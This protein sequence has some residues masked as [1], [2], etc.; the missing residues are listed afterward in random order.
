MVGATFV[1][2]ILATGWAVIFFWP[3]PVA[4]FRRVYG[5]WDLLVYHVTI[6]APY[7]GGIDPRL[8]VYARSWHEHYT[9]T[10]RDRPYHGL[11]CEVAMFVCQVP[12]LSGFKLWGGHV[13]LQYLLQVEMCGCLLLK[14]CACHGFKLWCGHVCF[15]KYC[16][17]DE[18]VS[19]QS[20]APATGLSFW[21]IGP[22][23]ALRDLLN[24]PRSP[25]AMQRQCEMDWNCHI[26]F[27]T[28]EAMAATWYVLCFARETEH[29]EGRESACALKLRSHTGHVSSFWTAGF[30]ESNGY[31]GWWSSLAFFGF[32]SFS[33]DVY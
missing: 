6:A 2:Q 24:T 25:A 26:C 22:A 21:N 23:A 12:Q 33:L 20:T 3:E 4:F 31:L 28:G 11:S 9:T 27:F 8:A 29:I 10:R 15:L 14:C 1:C 30:H 17:C 5:T 13:C 19:C 32:S 16:A 18:V 7:S